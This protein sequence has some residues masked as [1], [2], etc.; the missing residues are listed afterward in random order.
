MTRLSLTS[1]AAL[2]ALS[3]AIPASTQPAEARHRG[4]AIVGGVVLGA[5][6]LAI[7]ANSNRAHADDYSDRDDRHDRWVRHCQRLYSRC[8]HGSNS[9]CEDY[10]T[11]GCTE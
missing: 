11:G 10:E 1:L 4:A 8:Q 2:L 6:A 5:A 9:A 7:I 3:T